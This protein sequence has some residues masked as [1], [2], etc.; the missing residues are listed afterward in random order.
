MFQI[1]N[2]VGCLH[3]LIMTDAA[4]SLVHLNYIVDFE[5]NVASCYSQV[6]D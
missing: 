4:K 2:R 5:L 6:E 1:Y 3:I